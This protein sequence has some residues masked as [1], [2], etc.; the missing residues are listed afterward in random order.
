MNK[1]EIYTDGSFSSKTKFGGWGVVITLDNNLVEYFGSYSEETTNNK[2]ELL[3]FLSALEWCE[4]NNSD[5]EIDIFT[6]SSYIANCFKDG[7][8]L[9][10]EANGW[11]TSDKQSVKN[12]DLWKPILEL[13]RKLK[14][15][16]EININKVSAHKDNYWNNFADTLAV[17]KRKEIELKV[18]Y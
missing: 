13:Y 9:N 11:R 4:K 14:E 5:K 1:Y 17:K 18:G 15:K 12:Q 7:W 2:M 3:A 10:W 8:Y 6:D 16:A